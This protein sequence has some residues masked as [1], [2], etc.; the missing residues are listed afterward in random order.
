[1]MSKKAA[2]LYGRMQHGLDERQSGI[3]RLVQKRDAIEKQQRKDKRKIVIISKDE[4]DE[5]DMKAKSG[6]R[7]VEEKIQ[8][9]KKDEKGSSAQKQKAKRLK[10][11]RVQL[12]RQFDKQ[13]KSL[14][15]PKKK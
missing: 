7:R 9:R 3:E 14:K 10:D 8:G 6:L 13:I 15:K 1:M 4:E 2:R 12:N 11:E 5:I